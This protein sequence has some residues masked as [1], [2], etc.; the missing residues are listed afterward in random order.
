MDRKSNR[1]VVAKS[2]TVSNVEG[3][4][5][6]FLISSIKDCGSNSERQVLDWQC[7]IIGVKIVDLSSEEDTQYGVSCRNIYHPMMLLPDGGRELTDL[8]FGD[9]IQR[10]RKSKKIEESAVEPKSRT[11]R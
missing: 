8:I 3:R 6:Q 10:H 7:T 11:K 2:S 1:I 4:I 5:Y 9:K